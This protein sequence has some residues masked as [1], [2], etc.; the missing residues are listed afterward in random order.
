VRV[1]LSI[2]GR[3]LVDD[4]SRVDGG[5]LGRVYALPSDHGIDDG[6]EDWMWSPG[7]PQLIEAQI[8]LRDASGHLLDTVES[9]TAL[10]SV[11]IDGDR[12]ALNGRPYTLRMVLDQGYWPDGLMTA[13]PARLKRDVEL[14]K[15]LGFNGARLR[16]ARAPALSARWLFCNGTSRAA[17]RIRRHRLHH[18][19]RGLGLF[20]CDFR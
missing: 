15:S 12:F 20:G 8:E 19:R 13:D 6:R 7:H 4:T 14:I 5:E 10:R 9:Y 16:A 11:C 2:N 1:R 17:H 18:G 3:T